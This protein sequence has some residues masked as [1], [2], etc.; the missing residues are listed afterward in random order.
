MGEGH[1]GTLMANA[2]PNKKMANNASA[3]EPPLGDERLRGIDPKMVEHIQN[4]RKSI[5]VKSCQ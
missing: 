1:G 5:N 3:E 2:G 4:G